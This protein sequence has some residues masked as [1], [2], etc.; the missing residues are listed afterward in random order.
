MLCLA[1]IGHSCVTHFTRVYVLNVCIYKGKT[2]Q[3]DFLMNDNKN[4]KEFKP[5]ISADRVVPEFTFTSVITGLI[6]AVIFGAANA[7]LGLRVGMTIS[8]S[9]P[10]AVIGMGVI[11]VIFRKNSVLEGNMI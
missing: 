4:D 11:K 3:E 2:Q 10:A 9:I 1:F 6:L 5:Y 7:Y 8:A